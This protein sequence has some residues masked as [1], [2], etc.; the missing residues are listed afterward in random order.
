MNDTI[1]EAY[2]MSNSP[3]FFFRQLRTNELLKKATDRWSVE[4]LATR[5]LVLLGGPPSLISL[6]LGFA[7]LSA[8]RWKSLEELEACQ[9]LKLVAGKWGK[10][11]LELARTSGRI[12]NPPSQNLYAP[13]RARITA[14]GP[15]IVASMTS[16]SATNAPRAIVLQS[17]YRTRASDTDIGERTIDHD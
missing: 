11:L 7:Y 17:D 12:A 2:L 14:P 4:Q 16:S 9:E 15:S 3:E 5:A 10:T 13:G 8:L 6:S 1:R